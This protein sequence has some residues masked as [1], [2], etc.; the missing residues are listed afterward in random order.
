MEA[1]TTLTSI[2]IPTPASRT[3]VVRALISTM[4]LEM[5]MTTKSMM[6]QLRS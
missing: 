5:I 1:A 2:I 4:T 6:T 3:T